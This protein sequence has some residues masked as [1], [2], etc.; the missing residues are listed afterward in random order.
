MQGVILPQPEVTCAPQ[1]GFLSGQGDGLH[2]ICDV[3]RL[4]EAEQHQVIA[5]VVLRLWGVLIQEAHVEVRVRDGFADKP[6][7]VRRFILQKVVFA[8][9]NLVLAGGQGS[10][11]RE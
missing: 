6:V 2:N 7:L 11:Q 5:V 10:R 9:P 4:A 1:L 8:Q 3:S